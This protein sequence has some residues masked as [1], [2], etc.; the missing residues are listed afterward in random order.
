MS[1]ALRMKSSRSRLNGMDQPTLSHCV[2]SIRGGSTKAFI[3]ALW[4]L[5]M[6]WFHPQ[7]WLVLGPAPKTISSAFLSLEHLVFS[8]RIGCLSSPLGPICSISL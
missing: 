1:K 2:L 4:V 7:P 3:T 5:M 6:L 8:A